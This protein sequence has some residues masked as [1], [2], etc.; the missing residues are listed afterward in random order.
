MKTR[1]SIDATRTE[2][3]A[4]MRAANDH[5]MLRAAQTCAKLSKAAEALLGRPLHM[6]PP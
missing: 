2:M 1:E 5:S 3:L 6:P 4:L